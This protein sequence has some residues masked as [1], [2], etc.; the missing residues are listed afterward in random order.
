MEGGGGAGRGKGGMEGERKG[1]G[2]RREEM[3]VGGWRGGKREGGRGEALYICTEMSRLDLLCRGCSRWIWAAA[4][5]LVRTLGQS[6]F[7]T[8]GHYRLLSHQSSLGDPV[9]S[10]SSW[11]QRLRDRNT[12]ERD[13]L[14]RIEDTEASLLPPLGAVPSKPVA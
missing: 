14:N 1:V 5:V 11:N 12:T 7:Q 9:F 10:E 4:Q 6:C 8:L 3:E 2:R 13:T